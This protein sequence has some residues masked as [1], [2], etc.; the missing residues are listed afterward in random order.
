MWP[1]LAHKTWPHYKCNFDD[2][3]KGQTRV[4]GFCAGNVATLLTIERVQCGHNSNPKDISIYIYIYI[5]IYLF[6]YYP[7]Q[8]WDFRELLSGPSLLF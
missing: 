1:R 8:V 3:D 7:G 5:Y 6:I 2:T 4:E